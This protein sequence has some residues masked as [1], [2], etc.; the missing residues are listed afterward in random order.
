LR[1]VHRVSGVQRAKIGKQGHPRR[2][3]FK[4]PQDRACTDNS[5][6]PSCANVPSRTVWME[7]SNTVWDGGFGSRVTVSGQSGI[8]GTNPGMVQGSGVRGQTQSS[9]F[10][11][12][13]TVHRTGFHDSCVLH[14]V[15]SDERPA[16]TTP[17][18]R[19]FAGREP[20]R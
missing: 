7:L 14:G 3:P 5:F 19:R 1:V 18:F 16:D 13:N 2:I 15:S 9:R 6:R 12:K 17:S 4:M 10:D 11:L 8:F 20:E